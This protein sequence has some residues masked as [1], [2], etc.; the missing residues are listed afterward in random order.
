[1]RNLDD[2]K[3]RFVEAGVWIRPF[4]DIIYTT[5]PYVISEADLA[6]L[7]RTMVEVTAAWS[8]DVGFA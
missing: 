3:R 5:P 4:R 8:K 2:L 1:M 6:V 7:T